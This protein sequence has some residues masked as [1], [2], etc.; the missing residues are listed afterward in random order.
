MRKTAVSFL[1]AL[2]AFGAWAPQPRSRGSATAPVMLEIYS[3]YQCPACKALYER[4]LVPLTYDYVDRGKVFLVH[5]EFP[6]PMHPH[7]ME[8]ATYACA[9]GRIGRYDQVADVLFRN[10]EAWAV[11]G[12]VD[13]TACSI[14]SREEAKKVRTLA[15]DPSITAEIQRD[16]QNGRLANVNQTPTLIMTCKGKQYRIPGGNYDLLRRFIDQLLAN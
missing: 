8:A 6:L 15:K 1:L 10:Q 7:A 5:H 9:A 16:I 3:D 14:L 2:T 12:K 11:S 13:E 4:T